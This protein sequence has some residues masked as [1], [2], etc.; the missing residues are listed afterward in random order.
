MDIDFLV[1]KWCCKYNFQKVKNI[2]IYYI[3]DIQEDYICIF[4]LFLDMYVFMVYC[5]FGKKIGIGGF[6]GYDYLKRINQ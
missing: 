2:I 5:M 4:F 3:N 1:L 6:L